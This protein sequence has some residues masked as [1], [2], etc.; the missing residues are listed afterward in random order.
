MHRCVQLAR[1]KRASHRLAYMDAQSVTN[2]AM[3]VSYPP[4]FGRYE[5]TVQDENW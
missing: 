2:I 3:D 4:D 1:M 5:F